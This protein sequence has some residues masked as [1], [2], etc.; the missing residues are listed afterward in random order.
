M[1]PPTVVADAPVERPDEPRDIPQVVSR[2]DRIFRGIS[3]TA[4]MTALLIVGATAFFL[5]WRSV[6]AIRAG[7]LVDFFTTSAWNPTR[8][9]FGVEGL[10]MGTILIGVIALLFAVPMGI[11]LSLFINE[12]A[13]GRIKGLLVSAVDLLA[14]LPSLIFGMWGLFALQGPLIGVSKWFGNHLSAIPIFHV[15][16]SDDLSR[17]GFIGG[18]VVGLMIL[19]II[20]SVSREV[21]SQCPRD[22]CEAALGLGGTRWG[23]IRAV[24]L[25]FSRSGVVGAVLLGFG[26]ALG[27]T[28]AVTIIVALSVQTN[29]GVLTNGGGSIAQMIATK[30]GEA[31]DLEI[32]ALIGAGAALFLVTVVVNLFARRIVNRAG[33]RARGALL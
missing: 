23:M 22:Q 5:I 29:W 16:R 21:M 15:Q 2:P 4:A 14:A 10:L 6:P 33:S 28:I 8:K 27:E 1:P 26:R 32:S 17:S 3:A 7:G 9:R 19:P 18:V 13:P 24:V 12:Y 31:S 25:P 20:T 30:F 11:G